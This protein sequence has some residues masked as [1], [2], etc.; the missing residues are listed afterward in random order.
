MS[1]DGKRTTR[2]RA[3]IVDALGAAGGFRTAQELHDELR[4]AGARVGL[5]T[6][7]RNLQAL[8]DAGDVDVVRN[9]G[10]ESMYRRCARGGHHHHIVCRSCGW[11]AEIASDAIETWAT[12][13]AR[14]HGFVDVTHT[15]EVYG[16]CPSCGR[17]A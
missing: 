8:A 15:A 10:G 13:A 7:Y 5:T 17:G 4:A 9:P 2:Q 11:S 12:R 6:V 1:G 14:R 3:A 16:L